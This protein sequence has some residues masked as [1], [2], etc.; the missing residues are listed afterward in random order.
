MTTHDATPYPSPDEP[1]RIGQL[2]G[3]VFDLVDATVDSITDAEVD[4]VLRQV[5][6]DGELGQTA[7]LDELA[8][9]LTRTDWKVSPTGPAELAAWTEVTVARAAA[10]AARAEARIHTAA[11]AKARQQAAEVI[12]GAKAFVDKALDEAE[13]TKA[14]AEKEAA[15]L[16]AEAKQQAE[17]IIAAA[18]ASAATAEPSP[19]AHRASRNLLAGPGWMLIT[20]AAGTGK[21]QLATGLMTRMAEA[22]KAVSGFA[23]AQWCADLA[24]LAGLG[25]FAN[26]LEPAT[27]A[28]CDIVVHHHGAIRQALT[29]ACQSPRYPAGS[30]RRMTVFQYAC[31]DQ[32]EADRASTFDAPGRCLAAHHGRTADAAD[33]AELFRTWLSLAD[34]KVSIPFDTIDNCDIDAVARTGTWVRVDD[35][36]DAT[37]FRHLVVQ[38]KRCHVDSVTLR[39]PPSIT[40][41]S[42]LLYVTTAGQAEQREAPDV[43][44]LRSAVNELPGMQQAGRLALGSG[45]QTARG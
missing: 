45:C 1:E 29:S 3:E 25:R 4:R 40:L 30:L 39:V 24:P 32:L 10:A 2:F 21:T 41:Q 35:C 7:N 26:L 33:W 9:M 28:F 15:R 16:I 14:D 43:D 18:R 19:I 13:T 36:P 6:V 44:D 20:G 31:D 27:T 11:A 23:A 12:A 8:E 5:Y 34:W 17:E 38:M 42:L 22:G 37:T